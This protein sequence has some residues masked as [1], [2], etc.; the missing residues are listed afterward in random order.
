M[1]G[2]VAVAVVLGLAAGLLGMFAFSELSDRA[3]AAG[4][5]TRQA[6]VSLIATL[7]DS[8]KGI[9]G[10]AY[11]VTPAVVGI[12][13]TK[14]PS[15][16][17]FT[18]NV[19]GEAGSASAHCLRLVEIVEPGIPHV[20]NPVTG[21]EVC[22]SVSDDDEYVALQSGPITLPTGNHMYSFQWKQTDGILIFTIGT[23]RVLAEWQEYSPA[24]GGTAL[25]PNISDSSPSNYIALAALAGL[26]LVALSGGARYVRR[27]WSR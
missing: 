3:G 1:R 18:F 4:Y 16:T 25:L 12:D 5:V 2:I 11:N 23:I 19:N 7:N 24:V 26:A 6:E 14:F 9:A 22:T 21:S 27:R 17:T 15:G 13:T 8:V 10:E 20:F